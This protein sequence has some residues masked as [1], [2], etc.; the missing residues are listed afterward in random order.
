MPVLLPFV[1]VNVPSNSHHILTTYRTYICSIISTIL[2]QC[3]ATDATSYYSWNIAIVIFS[4]ISYW[5][6]LVVVVFN[7]NTM[8]RRQ[9]DAGHSNAIFKIVPLA[10]LGLMGLLSCAA[11]GMSAYVYYGSGRRFSFRY[12]YS[13]SY[14]VVLHP[15]LALKVAYYSLYL[16]SLFASGGLA[17][18]TIMSLRRAR[19]A[20][21]VSSTIA[22][23]NFCC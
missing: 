22:T 14:K 15:L 13:S 7:L 4:Y 19:K 11:A 21:G 6:F 20:G 8:L 3:D 5:L 1:G 23:H 17:L 2:L 18:M 10:I 12:S 16:I 9:L